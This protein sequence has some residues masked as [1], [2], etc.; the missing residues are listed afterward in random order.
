MTPLVSNFG[1]CGRW[2][3]WQSKW[4]IHSRVESI[5]QVYESDRTGLHLN[6][7]LKQ[8]II[9]LPSIQHF[10]SQTWTAQIT[11]S[12]ALYGTRYNA[13]LID[14]M[15][16]YAWF[17]E[18][19]FCITS[20]ASSGFGVRCICTSHRINW[21]I[22]ART[23]QM[24]LSFYS[25]STFVSNM[26]CKYNRIYIWFIEIVQDFVHS[27]AQLESKDKFLKAMKDKASVELES[28]IQWPSYIYQ[29]NSEVTV[30]CA[31]YL[32]SSHLNLVFVG[33]TFTP[34][35]KMEIDYLLSS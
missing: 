7:W 12:S 15:S 10:T 23:T 11:L 4:Q 14:Q 9:V 33:P 28:F 8:S 2:S 24:S 13:A 30:H 20:T 35:Y 27:L 16:L 18:R 32:E 6:C 5:Y 29:F 25:Y 34:L 19:L 1:H 3:T 21:S 17:I 26:H 22:D 31:T